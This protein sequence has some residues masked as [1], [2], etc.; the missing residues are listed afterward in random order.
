[1]SLLNPLALLVAHEKQ[2][3]LNIISGDFI[4]AAPVNQRVWRCA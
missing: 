1:M 4:F 3:R 2:S